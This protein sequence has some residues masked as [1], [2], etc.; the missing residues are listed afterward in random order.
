MESE[1]E[2][3]TETLIQGQTDSEAVL[4]AEETSRE[5]A[6]KEYDFLNKM[7]GLFGGGKGGKG[8]GGAAGGTGSGGG[9]MSVVENMIGGGIVAS[10]LKFIATQALPVVVAAAGGLAIGTG[11]AY[12]INKLI[13][14]DCKIITVDDLKKLDFYSSEKDIFAFIEKCMTDKTSLNILYIYIKFEYIRGI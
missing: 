6:D 7:K 10:S 8:G 12:G 1:T 13:D 5:T 4:D 11:V 9:I 2:T 14:L 3:R